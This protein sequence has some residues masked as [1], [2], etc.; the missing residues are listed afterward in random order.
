M[1]HLK[2][3]TAAALLGTACGAAIAFSALAGGEKVAFPEGF[4]QKDKGALYSIVDRYDNKQYRELW[5]SPP[6]VVDLAREGKPIPSGTVLTLVQYKAQLDAAGNPIKGPNGRFLKGDLVAYTVMEKRTG[7]G[8]EYPDSLRNGEWEYQAFSPDKKVNDKANL[9]G[10]FECHKPHAGQD[11]VISLASLK[12]TKPGEEARPQ[13]GPGIVSVADFKFGPETVVVAPG[14][15]ITWYNADG[16]PHQVTI[17]G[18]KGQ[19][20]PI[21]QKGQT[22]K[23]TLADAGIYDYICGLHPAMKGKIEVKAAN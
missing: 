19:R 16:S 1:R 3:A 12:G 9:K 7:W 13:P 15:Q 18:P 10:C 4:D 17:T 5:A 6:S 2:A 11:F 23:L 8:T 21:I 22:T 14:Q 20:T